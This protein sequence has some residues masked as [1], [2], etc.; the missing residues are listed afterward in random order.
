MDITQ[1]KK[2]IKNK[3]IVGVLYQ[4]NHLVLKLNNNNL[5]HIQ[6]S[7]KNCDGSFIELRFFNNNHLEIVTKE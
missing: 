6:T 3:E 1:F 4:N 2:D 5:I 7:C